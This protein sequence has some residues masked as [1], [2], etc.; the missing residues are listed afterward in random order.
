M[1][2]S[3]LNRFL[4]Q[5][6]ARHMCPLCRVADKVDREYIWHFFDEYSGEAWALDALRRARGF[7]AEHAD[8]LRRVEYEGLRSTLGISGVYLDTLEGV[9]GEFAALRPGGRLREREPCPA[10]RYRDD[11]V[12]KNATYLVETLRDDGR[13]RERFEAGP[14]LCMRHFDLVWAAARGPADQELLLEVQRR[15]IHNLRQEL[16]EHARKQ[17]HEAAGEAPGEEADS[18]QR[19]MYLTGGWP[20]EWR[21]NGDR[22]EGGSP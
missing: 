8:E 10:C 3:A 21:A 15:S 7:C 1:T 14:G 17:G 12:E 22:A 19:A 5:G 4:K 9:E 18:W 16:L 6:L 2:N 20:Q 11:E 13:A